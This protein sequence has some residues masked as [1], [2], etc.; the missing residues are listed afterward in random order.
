MPKEVNRLNLIHIS[1]SKYKYGVPG[2]IRTR[3]P[4]LRRQLLCPTELQGRNHAIRVSLTRPLGTV[5]DLR[6]A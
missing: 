1:I 5:K 3:D 4:L 2:R 6:L